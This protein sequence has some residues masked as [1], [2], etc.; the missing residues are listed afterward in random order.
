MGLCC[1][2]GSILQTAL[3]AKERVVEVVTVC[4]PRISNKEVEVEVEVEEQADRH[5]LHRVRNPPR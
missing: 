3:R 4:R 1:L 2:S 5:Y